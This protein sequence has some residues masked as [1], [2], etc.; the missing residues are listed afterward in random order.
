MTYEDLNIMFDLVKDVMKEN[1]WDINKFTPIEMYLLGV[2]LGQF[3]FDEI[4][5]RNEPKSPETKKIYETK[6]WEDKPC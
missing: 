1:G 5:R 4:V 6:E 2:C 3:I